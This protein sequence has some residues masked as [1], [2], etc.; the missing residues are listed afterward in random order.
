MKV[1]EQTI[2]NLYKIADHLEKNV[3]DEQ[4]NISV[5]RGIGNGRHTLSECSYISKH[6]CGT[7]GCAIGH[8]VFIE[9]LEP[10]DEEFSPNFDDIPTLDFRLYRNRILKGVSGGDF[11][12][13]FG[14]DNHD[15]P[16]TKT[17]A[18]TIARIRELADSKGVI[19][20]N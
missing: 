17:R 13:V 10:I 5:W 18:A 3:T 6:E 16:E 20:G 12:Y 14:S 7:V 4:F 8:A 9:G 19:Y 11:E 2:V 15:S 1:P